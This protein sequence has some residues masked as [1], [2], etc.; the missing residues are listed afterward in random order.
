ML[1]FIDESGD[2]GFKL[3]KG[4]SEYFIISLVVFNDYEEANACDNR[5]ELLKRELGK[6]SSWEFHFKENTHRIR[7]AFIDAVID[8]DF[9][10]Y[11]IVINKH[12]LFSENLK[13]SKDSFFKYTSSLVFENAK[14]KLDNAI[15]L[16]DETGDREFKKSFSKY[17]K[18]RMNDYERKVIKKIKTQKSH[19]NNLL[20]LA[21]YVAGSINR[22]YSDKKLAKTYRRKFSSREMY[23]QEWPKV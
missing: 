21:D 20:Q 13:S 6:P 12:L 19:S 17:L 18:R 15:V 7:E 1:V 16:I 2:S 5:I 4:S 11:G 9:F 22:S 3:D 14:D 10:Y 8:Y 23:V